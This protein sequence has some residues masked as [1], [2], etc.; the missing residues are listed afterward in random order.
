MPFGARRDSLQFVEGHPPGRAVLLH[1]ISVSN[2]RHPVRGPGGARRR[3]GL[4]AHRLERRACPRPVERL[5]TLVQRFPTAQVGVPRFRRGF[6][7][8]PAYEFASAQQRGLPS[9]PKRAADGPIG[10][11]MLSGVLVVIDHVAGTCALVSSPLLLE[12]TDGCSVRRGDIHR[13]R[14]MEARFRTLGEE[15]AEVLWNA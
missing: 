9:G 7:G 12:D 4:V 5:R 2:D 3:A 1:W 13:L 11:F 10:R 8:D 6:V 15:G 14:A